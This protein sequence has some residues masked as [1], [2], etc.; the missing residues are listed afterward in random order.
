[1]KKSVFTEEQIAYALRQ[2]DAGTPVADGCRGLGIS[3]AT[4]YV[5][6]KKY[7]S[8][9]VSALRARQRSAW[10]DNVLVERLLMTMKYERVYLH[11]HDTV[12]G[13]EAWPRPIDRVLQPLAATSHA[14]RRYARYHVLRYAAN[15]V[16]GL[17]SR[18][19]F[20]SHRFC[21]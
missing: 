18:A 8:L 6:K 19:A 5:R 9:G 3:E 17:T 15:S 1:M 13:A 11:A 14:S 16:D 10:R 2:A 20:I 12:S 4:F 21:T 7:A